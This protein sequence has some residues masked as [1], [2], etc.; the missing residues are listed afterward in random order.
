MLQEMI[1]SNPMRMPEI[2]KN[3]DGTTGVKCRARKNLQIEIRHSETSQA[4]LMMHTCVAYAMLELEMEFDS[5][6]HVAVP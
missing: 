4:R 5:C 3:R 6:I 2:A 1:I